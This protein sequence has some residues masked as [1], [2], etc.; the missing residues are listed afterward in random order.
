[1]R[2][3]GERR[4]RR[5]ARA[6]THIANFASRKGDNVELRIESLKMLPAGGQ[7]CGNLSMG[8]C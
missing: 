5:R 2:R 4:R 6:V 7:S 8:V 3:A 1:M